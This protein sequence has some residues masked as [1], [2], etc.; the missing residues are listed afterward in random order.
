[1]MVRAIRCVLTSLLIYF[2]ITYLGRYDLAKKGR[3]ELAEVNVAGQSLAAAIPDW[4][5]MPIS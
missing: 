2:D 5:T 1:M 4:L 3:H